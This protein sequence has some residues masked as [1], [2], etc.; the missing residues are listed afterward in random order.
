MLVRYNTLCGDSSKS[1]LIL[2]KLQETEL[3]KLNLTE[4]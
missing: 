4:L 1:N 3:K 2:V